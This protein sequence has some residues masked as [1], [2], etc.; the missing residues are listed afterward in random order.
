MT[1]ASPPLIELANV[2]LLSRSDSDTFV[3]SESASLS[4][5]ADVDPQII[6]ALKSKDRIYVLKLGEQME[7][8]INDRSFR[9]RL[10][11]MPATSYQRLLV[12]R[13]SAYYKL[14]PETDPVSKTI[15]VIPT[16]DSRIPTRRIAALVPAQLSSTHPTIKIM[17]R[18]TTDRGRS[19]PHSQAG[20]IAGEDLDLSDVEPSESGSQGG[21][22][23]ATGSSKKHK[24]IA[25]REAAYNEARS[26]IFMDFEEREKGKEKDL[27]ASC[28]TISLT[29]GSV[30]SAGETSSTGDLDIESVSSPTTE[31]EW[32]G[33]AVRDKR[34]SKRSNGSTRSLRSSAPVF[35]VCGS[36]SSRG[37]RAPSPSSFKYPT[38]Y[39][40]SPAAPPYDGAQPPVQPGYVNPYVYAYPQPP[41]PSNY[42][43]GYPYYA[44]YPYPHPQAPMHA[45]DNSA[46]HGT[47]EAYPSPQHVAHPSVY[48]PYTWSPA[49]QQQQLPHPPLQHTAQQPPNQSVAP[50]ASQYSTFTPPVPPYGPYPMPGYFPQPPHIPHVQSSPPTVQNHGHYPG[51]GYMNGTGGNDTM[52]LNRSYPGDLT[53][54]PSMGPKPRGAPPARSAWSY[55]PGVGMGGFGVNNMSG[56][57]PSGGEVV[58]PRLS[59]S[60]RRP[61]GNSNAS[62]GGRTLAGDEASSTAVSY[63]TRLC[64]FVIDSFPLLQSSSTTSSSSRRTF[65]STSSQHPL[66]ARPDWAVGL[67]PQPTLHATHPR[68]HDHSIN[69]RTM[70]PARNNSQRGHQNPPASL[71]PTDFPPLSTMS[72]AAEKRIPAVA[73]VWTNSSSTRSILMP[74]NNISHGNPP[75]NHSNTQSGVIGTLCNTRLED[76]DGGFERPPPK[77]NVELF[78][79]KGVWKPGGPQSRSPPGGSQD[80]DK[81]EKLRGEAVANAILVDKMA[82]V[83]VE[84]ND[85]SSNAPK[86]SPPVALAT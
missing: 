20:S 31:S 40:P 72:P 1:S 21:R 51:N 53:Q 79:P 57:R 6:E 75:A 62:A 41:P 65:T 50:P 22:S 80:K 32:S 7:S 81:M 14:A 45:P 8:L 35:N 54:S 60:V 43:P 27:S 24:T 74:G 30:T 59:S 9:T 16:L 39:E 55:G 67:K 58:G 4:V 36:S 25:E 83:S 29:S 77:G 13:C 33:P 34:D 44:P 64:S 70:S 23:N 73:G 49:Q 86:I 5:L 42:I 17:R 18:S 2:Q 69:S 47:M 12:H 46:V 3:E 76:T 61:S 26:R 11:L 68:H 48:V 28:S 85:A 63:F 15:S 84:D 19:K 66:P 10:D 56:S 71:H 82:M 52:P 78:N 37:S 38:L